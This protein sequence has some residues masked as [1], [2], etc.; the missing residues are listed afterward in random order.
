MKPLVSII[1]PTY[2]RSKYLRETLLSV[3]GQSF[4]NWEC[5]VVD[6]GSQDETTV[7]M[8]SVMSSETRIKYYKRPI[9]KQKGANSCRNYGFNLSQ[10]EFIQY[11]DDDDLLET[12]KL[13]IQ[14]TSLENTN[15]DA[16]ATCRWSY[17]KN[18][19]GDISEQDQVVYNSYENIELFIDAL[20]LSGGFLP[21]H[22]YLI[23]RNLINRAGEWNEC[24]M[25]NQDGE[26][27]SRIFT[28]IKRVIFSENTSVF[29]RKEISLRI[30]KLDSD[31]KI[32]HAILSW[33]LIEIAFKLKFGKETRLVAI[34]RKY[35]AER[36]SK[37]NGESK[38]SFNYVWLLLMKKFRI[39]I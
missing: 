9:D 5:I 39:K 35:L 12:N 38:S 20:A 27:M 28:K 29:Y 26:F 8:A 32:Q 37:I 11:L 25:I 2:N 4:N 34:S 18:K 16:L 24:L 17:F 15:N 30:S 6:D 13:A 22:S 21:P 1:I 14:L 10:G 23:P 36:I 19:P 7:L 3:I 31:L 33:D